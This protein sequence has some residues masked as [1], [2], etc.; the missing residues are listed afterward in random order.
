M[1]QL[2]AEDSDAGC[3][4]DAV[5]GGEGGAYSQTVGKVVH[6]VPQDDHDH[7]GHVAGW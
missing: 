4:A 2:V 5:A 1:R 6:C 3:Y 7:Q